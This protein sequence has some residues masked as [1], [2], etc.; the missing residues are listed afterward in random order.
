MTSHARVGMRIYATCTNRI[1]EMTFSQ[2]LPRGAVSAP[3]SGSA[4]WLHK[5][6][7]TA[8]GL[9]TY[10]TCAAP[11]EAREVRAREVFGVRD[12]ARSCHIGVPDF[13]QRR[14]ARG[15]R[16]LAAAG[17]TRSNLAEV[18]GPYETLPPRCICCGGGLVLMEASKASGGGTWI[19][20]AAPTA[21][22]LRGGYAG[23]S[24]GAL[25]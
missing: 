7:W 10:R 5:G 6:G 4:A 21:V 9:S 24:A 18:G 2:K 1:R 22:D 14:G 13:C 20:T 16:A 3:S 19:V 17:W 15:G 23:A 12:R 11:R 8:D 25:P